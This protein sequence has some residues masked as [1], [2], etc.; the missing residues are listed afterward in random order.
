MKAKT[1]WTLSLRW[2]SRGQHNAELI[3]KDM[4]LDNLIN[5]NLT[6]IPG[7]TSVLQN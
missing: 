1:N 4:L 5:T 6:K 3:H 2:N 7:W